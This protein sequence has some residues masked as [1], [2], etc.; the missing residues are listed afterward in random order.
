MYRKN[1]LYQVQYQPQ[2]QASPGDLGMSPQQIRG[3]LYIAVGGSG[4]QEQ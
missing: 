1:T 3:P 2:F 4:L